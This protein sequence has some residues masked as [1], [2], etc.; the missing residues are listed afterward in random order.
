VQVDDSPEA[1]NGSEISQGAPVALAV[2]EQ[3]PEA[4][5]VKASSTALEVS[6]GRPCSECG[7]A[8]PA[9][10]RAER[11][12]CSARCAQRRH[13]R[14][15]KSRTA[16]K[17]KALQLG[18]DTAAQAAFP[19]PVPVHVG[20]NGRE[21]ADVLETVVHLSTLLPAGWRDE[22]GSASIVLSWCVTDQVSPSRPS[23]NSR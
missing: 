7:G 9:G 18:T 8:L 3:L 15:R 12:T 19:G 17:M 5:G 11:A 23:T 2:P 1:S 10:S 14:L 4:N 6:M 21:D 22:V 20:Q 13:D 16:L